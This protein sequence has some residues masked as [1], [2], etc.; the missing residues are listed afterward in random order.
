MNSALA[1]YCQGEGLG[2]P[3]AVPAHFSAQCTYLS[4]RICPPLLY[5]LLFL[6]GLTEPNL[7]LGL[8]T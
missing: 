6:A 2:V 7:D 8:A 1:F 4:G 5:Y 3:L